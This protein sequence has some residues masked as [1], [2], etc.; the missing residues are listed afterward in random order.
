MAYLCNYRNEMCYPQALGIEHRTVAYIRQWHV[1]A[2]AS[3][4]DGQWTEYI[5]HLTAADKEW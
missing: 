4:N 5:E 2:Q 3:D 1:M